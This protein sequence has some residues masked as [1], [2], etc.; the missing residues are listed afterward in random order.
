[1]TIKTLI[2]E[3]TTLDGALMKCARLSQELIHTQRLLDQAESINAEKPL[4]QD[5]TALRNAAKLK[6]EDRIQEAYSNFDVNKLIQT[7]ETR[8]INESLDVADAM[9]GIDRTW[10]NLEIKEGR[11]KN[12]I[13]PS[14]DT[15]LH[16][17]AEPMILA[18]VARVL[19][20]KSIKTA[21]RDAIKNRVKSAIYSIEHHSSSD[22]GKKIDDLI[23]AELNEVF[24]EYTSKPT[25]QD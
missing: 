6:L 17:V 10:H 7:I 12:I 24:I 8:L 18:E 13:G 22:V 9:L 25:Q 21:I 11:I 2:E 15:L 14:I 5:L 20:L 16:E 3:A 19:E 1:M 23:K 4:A